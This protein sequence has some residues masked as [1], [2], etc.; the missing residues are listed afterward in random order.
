[1]QAMRGGALRAHVR[2]HKH[3][4]MHAHNIYTCATRHPPTHT[5]KHQ[6]EALR[7]TTANHLTHHLSYS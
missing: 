5:H 3:V 1:M 6:L 7:G 2:A 4:C